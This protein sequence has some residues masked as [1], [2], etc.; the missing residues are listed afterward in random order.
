MRSRPPGALLS[1]SFG[2]SLD[3]PRTLALICSEMRTVHTGSSSPFQA[4]PVSSAVMTSSQIFLTVEGW[5]LRAKKRERKWEARVCVRVAKRRCGVPSSP[6][7]LS[8]S[9]AAPHYSGAPPDAL[10]LLV[11]LHPVRR[12]DAGDLRL[13]HLLSAESRLKGCKNERRSV[14][15]DRFSSARFEQSLGRRAPRPGAGKG[16]ARRSRGRD[17]RARKGD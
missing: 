11:R 4:F 8:L 16:G 5:N 15:A 14:V 10:L 13:L 6:F 9:F 17:G 7:S 12:L 2:G 3:S 1:L